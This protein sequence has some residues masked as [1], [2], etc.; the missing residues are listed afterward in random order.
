M[1]PALVGDSSTYSEF[2]FRLWPCG[3]IR[4]TVRP[5]SLVGVYSVTKQ[6]GKSRLIIDARGTNRLFR[7]PPKTQLGSFEALTRLEIP[8]GSE[9]FIAQENWSVGNG[10]QVGNPRG[11][12][13]NLLLNS[14]LDVLLILLFTS[15]I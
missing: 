9:R 1:D 10:F 11:I 12:W 6:S 14:L 8:E 5:K 15:S 13:G 4:F 3:V 2:V 7:R